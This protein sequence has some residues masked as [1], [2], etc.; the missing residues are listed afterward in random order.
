MPKKMCRGDDET[1]ILIIVRF[2]R[3]YYAN[4]PGV[5][6]YTTLAELTSICTDSFFIVINNLFCNQRE[7]LRLIS[8]YAAM[9]L[10]W[11]RSKVM[12]VP[13]FLENR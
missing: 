8:Y 4:V 6:T 3:Y 11:T 1:I 12:G 13:S 9:Q 7:S 10:S 2:E 5:K